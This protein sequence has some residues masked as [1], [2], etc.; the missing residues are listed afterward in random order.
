M[1]DLCKDI[2]I[3]FMTAEAVVAANN[4]LD[5]KCEDKSLHRFCLIVEHY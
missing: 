1:L 4:V 5:I 3:K 2:L